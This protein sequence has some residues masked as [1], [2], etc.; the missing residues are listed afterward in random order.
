MDKKLEQY[1]DT[2]SCMVRMETVSVHGRPEHPKFVEFRKLLSELFPT[3][4]AACECHYFKNGLALLWKGK[5]PDK[6]PV[7]F[8]NHSDVVEASGE[9]SHDPFSAEVAD[10]KLWGRGTLDDKGGLWAM[11]QAAQELSEEG[12]VPNRD[13]WLVSTSTE[14]TDGV[15][16]K[17]IAAWFKAQGI[18]FE[19]SYDEGG[20][21]IHEPIDG[22]DATFA[23]IGVG[24]KGCA[25]LKFIARSE[26]G[27]ASTP[28]KNTPL[29]RL[30]KFMAA[31]DKG[32]IF[33]VKQEPTVSEMLRRFLP[34]MGN[35][36]K[37]IK[38]PAKLSAVL[39]KIVPKLSPEAA[40][41]FGTTIA[42]T[43]AEGSGGLNVLPR[44]AWVTGNM[45]YSHHEGRKEAFRKIYRLAK[46]YDVEMEIIDPGH[47]SRMTDYNGEAFRLAERAVAE[48]FPGVKT[49]PYIM[50]GASD[51]RF[52]DGVSD[53]CIR[54]LPFTITHEQMATIHG[55]DEN[56]DIDTL[57]PAVEYYRFLYKEV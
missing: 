3:L 23:M 41:L 52:F 14:E 1:I 20:M 39:E 34:H 28:P 12:F 43:M 24:E 25:D 56:V 33:E 47:P 51:S 17:E 26:G 5:D 40:A 42:F 10:G 45:R 8:L 44:E 6:R 50:T 38:D 22:V 7:L 9:W 2:L 30:G 21:I 4:F 54:F 48:I 11:M 19:M 46:R 57:K 29:V 27:H 18:H 37:L 49:A 32:S 15:G 53:Q 31:V 36:G 13:L 35:V 16:A 55:T